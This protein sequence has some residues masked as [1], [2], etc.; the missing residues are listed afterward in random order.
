MDQLVAEIVRNC[1]NNHL[2]ANQSHSAVR[3]IMA[4]GGH[5]D[6]V[7]ESDRGPEEV[8]HEALNHLY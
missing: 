2:L 6:V 8:V 7:W 4:N 1:R 5:Y 3:A